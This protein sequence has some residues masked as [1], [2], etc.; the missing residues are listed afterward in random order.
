[1]GP[2]PRLAACSVGLG[3]DTVLERA[4]APDLDAHD[5]F[6]REKLRR[7]HRDA[8]AVRCRFGPIHDPVDGHDPDE[9]HAAAEEGAEL[10]RPVSSVAALP[11]TAVVRT[12]S[13]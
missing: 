5:V 9:R 3:H 1:M 11:R 6:D 8:D 7:S 12:Y 10:H 4:E 13:E 2:P